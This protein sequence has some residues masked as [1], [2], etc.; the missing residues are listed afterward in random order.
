MFLGKKYKILSISES[1]KILHS[2]ISGN[3]NYILET[4]IPL[5]EV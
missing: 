3:V 4:H 1:L 5:L 2:E